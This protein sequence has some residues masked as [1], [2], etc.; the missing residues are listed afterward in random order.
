MATLNPQA[1]AVALAARLKADAMDA[2]EARASLMYAA[3]VLHQA[4]MEAAVPAEELKALLVL[5]RRA[6][7]PGGK[8][9]DE[10]K[11]EIALATG[12]HPTAV[13]ALEV[14]EAVYFR[15]ASKL[16]ADPAP[17]ELPEGAGE[18]LPAKPGQP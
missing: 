16:P 17:L 2:V 13:K 11:A 1:E 18:A 15:D 7:Q 6:A 4:A 5:E 3:S 12:K 10:Q 9:V 8:S 14:A